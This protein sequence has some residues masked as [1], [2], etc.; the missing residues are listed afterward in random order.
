MRIRQVP[1]QLGFE[2]SIPVTDDKGVKNTRVIISAMRNIPNPSAFEYYIGRVKQLVFRR[3]SGR[4]FNDKALVQSLLTVK[5]G[6]T[7]VATADRV[8]DLTFNRKI[9]DRQSVEPTLTEQESVIFNNSPVYSMDQL[10]RWVKCKYSAQK[11][12]NNDF[13]IE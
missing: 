10:V 2:F 7:V 8:W 11:G 5:D 3:S 6:F 13:A 4:R 12:I 1:I 9:K